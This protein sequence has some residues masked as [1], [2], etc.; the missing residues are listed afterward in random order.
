MAGL[1]WVGSVD[2]ELRQLGAET[3]CPRKERSSL[4]LRLLKVLT[5]PDEAHAPDD[6]EG[7]C[8]SRLE[9]KLDLLMSLFG[10]EA[11]RDSQQHEVTLEPKG[12]WVHGGASATDGSSWEISLWLTADQVRPV[13]LEA[14]VS[15]QSQDGEAA[16]FAFTHVSP[17]EAELLERF[18]FQQHRR[19]VAAARRGRD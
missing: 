1:A 18:I 7:R 10:V 17:G 12:I 11:S 2:L 3:P 19:A 13:I 16:Y 4:N 6:P 9:A 5:M 15:G 14:V 8:C